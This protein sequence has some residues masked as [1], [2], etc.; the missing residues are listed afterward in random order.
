MKTLII[1]TISPF[2]HVIPWK[3]QGPQLIVK[4]EQVLQE[5]WEKEDGLV[6]DYLCKILISTRSLKNLPGDVVRNFL[7]HDGRRNIFPY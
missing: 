6:G 7:F 2:V 4:C 5:V 1:V 3:L